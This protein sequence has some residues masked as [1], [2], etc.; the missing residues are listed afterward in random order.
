MNAS[1]VSAAVPILIAAAALKKQ[2]NP[3]IGWKKIY[4]LHVPI[5]SGLRIED[6]VRALFEY[7]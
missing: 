3:V 4:A 5:R 7:T 2:A 6:A 1:V